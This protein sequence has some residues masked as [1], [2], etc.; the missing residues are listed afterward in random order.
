MGEIVEG[1][2]EQMKNMLGVTEGDTV[3]HREITDDDVRHPTNY[4]KNTEPAHKV[5]TMV[6]KL[7]SELENNFLK[8]GAYLSLMH[9]ECYYIVLDYS[10]W[11]EYL[12]TPEIDLSRSQAYKLMAV[13]ERWLVKYNYSAEQLH[14]VSI[15]KLYIASSQASDDN[16]E[17]W[18]EKARTLSRSDLKACTPGNIQRPERIT[19]PICGECF[20]YYR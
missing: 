17:E 20:D 3:A 16:H 4:E 19:C 15:E 9:N 14:G 13:Y 8:L 10:T 7:K 12:D 2:F 6:C 11:Q 5:H 1:N 18:L